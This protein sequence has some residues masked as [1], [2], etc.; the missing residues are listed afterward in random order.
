MDF[1]KSLIL[2]VGVKIV[3]FNVGPVAIQ[4]GSRFIMTY[5]VSK[6]YGY[7]FPPNDKDDKHYSSLL[8]LRENSIDDKEDDIIVVYKYPTHPYVSNAMIVIDDYW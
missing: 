3:L 2:I 5:G 8:M 6:A 7:F 1:T 4:E